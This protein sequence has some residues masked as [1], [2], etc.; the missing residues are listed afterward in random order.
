M[1][2][3]QLCIIIP[4]K[5]DERVFRLLDRL[6][7]SPEIESCELIVA[8]N[9]SAPQFA[10]R[11][12]AELRSLP[13]ARV[14]CDDVANPARAINRAARAGES[15]KLLILDSDCEPCHGYLGFLLAAIQSQTT[16]RGRITFTGT[17]TFSR[18]S[19]RWRQS[20]Y[21]RVAGEGRL[22]APNIVIDRDLFLSLGGFVET[23]RH[24]YDSE[25]SDRALK[26]GNVAYF[27]PSATVAHECHSSV[28]TEMKIWFEYGRGRYYRM[29]GT[30]S[31]AGYRDA[32]LGDI[33]WTVL[34]D[35]R[36]VPYA[37][38]YLAVR[39]AGFVAAATNGN[40]RA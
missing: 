24:A 30:R 37:L 16:A 7:A 3:P 38:A 34:S 20:F 11:I 35:A 29:N 18:T 10:N 40:G 8:C 1:P 39:A 2:D 15:P 4:V 21:D 28:R 5:D 23:L 22:Y 32:L 6:A 12:E 13:H 9:G 19:A 31:A 17:T 26:S 25:F 33:P 36:I 27:I 14:L